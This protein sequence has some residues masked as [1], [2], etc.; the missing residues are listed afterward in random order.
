MRNFPGEPE[1]S[2]RMVDCKNCGK[3]RKYHAKN[4]CELCYSYLRSQRVRGK[5]DFQ[6]I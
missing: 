2:A 1:R 6:L 3:H 5:K 4:L